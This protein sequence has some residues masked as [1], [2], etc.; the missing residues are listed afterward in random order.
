MKPA[1]IKQTIQQR[2]GAFAEMGGNQETC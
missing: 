1:E 2:Y